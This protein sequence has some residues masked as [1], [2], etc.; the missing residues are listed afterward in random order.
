MHNGNTDA[1]A[2]AVKAILVKLKDDSLTMSTQQF[3]KA[4]RMFEALAKSQPA[5]LSPLEALF[6]DFVAVLLP[7]IDQDL[8]ILRLFLESEACLAQVQPTCEHPRLRAYT[9]G[10]TL[11]L[12]SFW[13][14]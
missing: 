10:Q 5:K 12:A 14:R 2:E 3:A 1:V 7:Q 6:G 13:I 8:A 4:S 9:H 11:I